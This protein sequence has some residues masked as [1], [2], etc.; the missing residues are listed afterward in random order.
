MGAVAPPPNVWHESSE[1]ALAT[2]SAL[3][4]VGSFL[5]ADLMRHTPGTHTIVV[6]VMGEQP[7]DGSG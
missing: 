4:A 1:S 2:Q 5:E 3:L 7:S 6:Q